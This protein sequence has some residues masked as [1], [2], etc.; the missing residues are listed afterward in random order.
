MSHFVETMAFRGERPW[1]WSETGQTGQ[2]RKVGHLA[3]RAEM[4]ASAGLGWTVEKVPL[5]WLAPEGKLLIVPD[6]FGIKRSDR[7]TPMDGVSVGSTFEPIQND[8]LFDFMEAVVKTGEAQFETAG[9][10]KGGRNVW[11]LAQLAGGIA[12]KRQRR[13]LVQEQDQHLAYLLCSMGHAGNQSFIANPTDVRVVCWNTLSMTFQDQEALGIRIRHTASAEERLA[14]AAKLVA[15]TV[16]SHAAWGQV[17]QQLADTPI[18]KERFTTFVCQLLTG[19]DDEQEAMEV[20]AKLNEKGGRSETI[21]NNKA[22]QIQD[23]FQ[24]GK[25]NAGRDGKDALDGVTEW[26]DH[27]RRRIQD[28]QDRAKAFESGQFGDGARL[29]RRAVKLLVG[30]GTD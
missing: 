18:S 13:G 20:V 27:Q 26:I 24:N 22:E 23:N 10:L 28:W 17:L 3:T 7:P 16:E 4:Q 1:H 8:A 2:S 15:E 25:G 6:V 29:K 30:G 5:G 12:V 14:H 19:K 11:G 21:F 9:C